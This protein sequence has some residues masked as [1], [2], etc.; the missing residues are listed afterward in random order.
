MQQTNNKHTNT[1]FV[2]RMLQLGLFR[3]RAKVMPHIALLRTR[4][5]VDGLCARTR[6]KMNKA[7]PKRKNHIFGG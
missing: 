1:H 7:R 6:I 3:A 4:T 5:R 2:A